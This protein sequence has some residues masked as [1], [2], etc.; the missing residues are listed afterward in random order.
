MKLKQQYDR[1][2]KFF[3]S[4]QNIDVWL[5]DY[6]KIFTLVKQTK[7]VEIIDSK[8]VYKNF[9]HLIEKIAF[10]FVEIYEFQLKKIID[11]E[12]KS[13]L[14]VEIFRHHMRMKKNSKKKNQRHSIR[15]LLWTKTKKT[16]IY[17]HMNL[18][19]EINNKSSR[20]VFAKKS[21]HMKIVIIS[22]KKF[23]SQNENWSRKSWSK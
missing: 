18:H 17:I 1:M 23:V 8:R 21:I 13:L 10:I 20:F 12:T 15:H 14:F 16:I 9:L 5:N 3:F 11:H 2:T 4:R 7:I 22:T 19:F 6:L